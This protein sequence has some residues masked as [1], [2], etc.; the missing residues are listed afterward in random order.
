MI[1]VFDVETIPDVDLVKDIYKIKSDGLEACNEAFLLQ[2]AKSGSSFLPVTFH[3]I[4]AISAVI[5]DEYGRFDRVS[6]IEGD[7]EYEI[8]KSFISFIDN[9][10]PRLI[11]FNGRG[12]DLPL[13]MIRAMRYNLSCPAY[14]D[15]NNQMLNKSK[16]DN[17]QTRYSDNFHLDLMDN[18]AEFGA[19]RGLNLD[20]ICSM[21]N[22]PGKYDVSGDMVTDLYFNHEIDKIREYCE[23]DVLNTYW[24]FLKYELLRG[25]L[26]ISDYTTMLQ[27]FL[28]K[29]PQDKSY[30]E[31]FNEY[32]LIEL[33]KF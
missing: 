3:Q 22:L 1:C 18:I 23:S 8:L 27:D 21:V 31:I 4:V 33:D 13:I 11:S 28:E 2:E 7:N 9:H 20:T 24:L 12:F 16:W 5:G 6:S 30:S 15:K 26:L 19:V 10:N 25:N 14:F 17:Y 32:L 29:L